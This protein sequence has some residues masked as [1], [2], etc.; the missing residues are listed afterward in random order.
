MSSLQLGMALGAFL[1]AAPAHAQD[2]VT[3]GSPVYSKPTDSAKPKSQPAVPA[4]P[5]T[6]KQAASIKVLSNLVYT[7][8]TVTDRS[9]EFVYDLEQKDFEILDNGTPQKIQSFEQEG[10]PVDLV[11]VVQTNDDVHPLLDQVRPLGP[12]FSNLLIGKQGSAAV[13]LYDDRVRVAQDFS[14]DS[15]RL[16][17]TVDL[18]TGRGDEARLNDALSRAVEMLEKRPASDRRIIVAFSTGFDKGSETTKEDVVRRATGAQVAI[19]GLGFNPAEALLK[20]PPHI[21]EPTPQD[22]NMALP[23][24]PNTV[25]TPS[26]STATYGAPMDPTS[27]VAAGAEVLRSAVSSS[28]LEYYSGFTG[29]VCYSHWAKKTLQE[30]LDKMASEI[31]SQYQL[32]YVP[33]NQEQGGFH[34]IE[35][36]VHRPGLKVRTR[37]GYYFPG[38]PQ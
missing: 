34:R 7:P 30:Q 11:V 10:G 6:A 33:D 29:G 27:V 1:M 25:P 28:P 8:V 36:R 9:G 15:D 17:G 13:V 19:Y 23:L 16:K 14:N 26:M 35:I 21:P 32:A 5:D 18:I 31:Q 37:A 4:G 20:K 3:G 38:K 24:P 12:I 2:D 22:N